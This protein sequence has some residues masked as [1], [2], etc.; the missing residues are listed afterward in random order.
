MKAMDSVEEQL[1]TWQPRHP[2][3]AVA[4]KLF[5][6]RRKECARPFPAWLWLSPAAAG[7]LLVLATAG[8]HPPGAGEFRQGALVAMILSNQSFAAYAPGSFQPSQNRW[9]TFEWTNTG[10]FLS[11][12]APFERETRNVTRGTH[13]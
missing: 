8:F 2:S 7:L 12:D 1:W 9:D 5:P 11:S 6:K 3:P 4:Q 13:P 10:G